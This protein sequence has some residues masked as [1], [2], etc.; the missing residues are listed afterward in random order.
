MHHPRVIGGCQGVVLRVEVL[1]VDL[2]CLKLGARLALLVH[3]SV[4]IICQQAALGHGAAAAAAG[5]L[6]TQVQ[7]AGPEHRLQHAV[8]SLE[9]GGTFE[10]RCVL[11]LP[12]HNATANIRPSVVYALPA[13]I[14]WAKTHA[15]V[16][17]A[18]LVTRLSSNT[19]HFAAHLQAWVPLQ[20]VPGQEP[21]GQVRPILAR[22][23]GVP[24]VLAWHRGM[25]SDH[26]K[27]A[28]GLQQCMKA[29]SSRAKSLRGAAFTRAHRRK[30]ACDTTKTAARAGSGCLHCQ[31]RDCL[32][33]SVC[34]LTTRCT[35]RPS[36]WPAVLLLP[37]SR[38][39]STSCFTSADV[40][41]Q[42]C[43]AS[44]V[45]YTLYVVN[46]STTTFLVQQQ[47]SHCLTH[48]ANTHSTACAARLPGWQLPGLAATAG[49]LAL[50]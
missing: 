8:G 19:Y 3:L 4:H 25:P 36:Y 41:L 27:L 15:A 48:F 42:Q 38:R 22:Q 30:P 9:H 39:F 13:L 24:R 11:A 46:S 44:G 12:Q 20:Y 7:A 34:A 31:C 45:Y 10:V 40:Y 47:H 43:Q 37:A 17:P 33:C 18:I 1:R 5:A 16:L 28:E 2:P 50:T 49:W 23:G 35:R 32:G 14:C 26:H 29:K 21:G 6:C